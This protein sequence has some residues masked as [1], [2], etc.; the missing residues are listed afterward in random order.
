MSTEPARAANR[1]FQLAYLLL[2]LIL[3]LNIA[4]H[5]ISRILTG[6]AHFAAT[7]IPQFQ[8]TPLANWAVYDFGLVLPWFEAAI[9]LLLFLGLYIR[10]SLIG[11][12][13]LMLA[14]TF[15]TALRQ[16]WN[17]A[18]TQLLYAAIYSAL[19]AFAAYDRYSLDTLTTHRRKPNPGFSA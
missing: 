18:A 3:G 9:G 14:L 10:L 12:S 8:S 5:G 2:R 13:L 17:I 15:G 6:T 11:G 1:D 4:M 16:D 19:L 7:L